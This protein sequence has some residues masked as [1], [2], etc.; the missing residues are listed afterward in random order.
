LKTFEGRGHPYEE[1]ILRV[2][3]G[4]GQS[5][6]EHHDVKRTLLEAREG[7]KEAPVS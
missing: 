2:E 3:V 5:I 4:G 6:V 1:N 7:T